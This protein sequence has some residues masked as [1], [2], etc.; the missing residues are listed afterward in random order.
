MGNTENIDR[1]RRAPSRAQVARHARKRATR[2]IKKKPTIGNVESST[3]AEVF[4][5]LT[6]RLEDICNRADNRAG[7]IQH[8]L[9]VGIEVLEK[10]VEAA[11]ETATS[12]ACNE[13][14][15]LLFEVEERSDELKE[16]KL[17]GDDE[18]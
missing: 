11:I 7:E 17:R 12:A 13:V 9:Q 10:K 8:E 6:K 14:E 15:E 1:I 16:R 5:L 2:K 18:L 3:Q 4:Q